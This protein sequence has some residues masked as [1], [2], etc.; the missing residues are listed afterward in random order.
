MDTTKLLLD[1]GEEAIKIEG[2]LLDLKIEK[3]LSPE[4]F[5]KEEQLL[6]AEYLWKEASKAY[7]EFLNHLQ[8]SKLAA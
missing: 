3:A 2:I 4:A 7:F 6:E 5:D 8:N 1:L